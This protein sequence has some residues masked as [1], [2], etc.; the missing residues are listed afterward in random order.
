MARQ[1]LDAGYQCIIVNHRG[2]GTTKISTPQ[3]YSASNTKDI[4]ESFE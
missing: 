4:E 2:V 3:T 1:A